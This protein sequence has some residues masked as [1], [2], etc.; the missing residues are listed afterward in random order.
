MSIAV[1]VT[2]ILVFAAIGVAFV[3][4]RRSSRRNAAGRELALIAECGVDLL[5]HDA[6]APCDLDRIGYGK[7]ILTA[8]IAAS[9]ALGAQRAVE[10]GEDTHMATR[11]LRLANEAFA[12]A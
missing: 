9:E 6:L 11:R 5:L 7:G 10:Y 3:Y 8:R 4:Q 1:V 2:A 12:I